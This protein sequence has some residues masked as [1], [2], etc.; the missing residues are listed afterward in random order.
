MPN[1]AQGPIYPMP[2]SG[3]QPNGISGTPTPAG[4]NPSQP[5]ILFNSFL[6][7]DSAGASALWPQWRESIP[8]A[9]HTT[10]S[11]QSGHQSCPKRTALS[12]TNGPLNSR[13]AQNK[14]PTNMM[15]SP[16]PAG[17]PSKEQ[18]K[19]DNK[20]PGAPNGASHVDGSPQN[21]PPNPQG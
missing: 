6:V 7:N 9:N 21:Q 19:D 8:V 12:A 3:P 17:C 18:P 15:P 2:S 1:G 16:S 14:Q 10:L 5:K 13:V 11:P 20:P 4:A